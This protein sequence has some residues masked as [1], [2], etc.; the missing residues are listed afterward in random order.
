M[1]RPFKQGLDYFPLDVDIFD[2][3]KIE[4]LNFKYGYLGEIIYIRLLTIIYRNGYYIEKTVSAVTKQ[5]IR[6]IGS[7]VVD[8]EKTIEEII[9]FLGELDLLEKS[10]LYKG[11][12][13]SKSIQKQFI[14]STKRR[15]RIDVK[16][17]WLLSKKEMKEL[18]FISNNKSIQ[19]VSNN[20]DNDNNN[21][22]NNNINEIVDNINNDYVNKKYT[23]ESKAKKSNDKKIN[24]KGTFQV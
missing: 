14:L 2:D 12:L 9:L 23:K 16:S 6:F 4:E 5:L 22:V 3:A 17:Y 10:L 7:S 11:V 1:A 18:N 19:V 8:K 15:K 13:T 20:L 21:E 24:D